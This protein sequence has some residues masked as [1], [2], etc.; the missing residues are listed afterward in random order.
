MMIVIDFSI[1]GIDRVWDNAE[2]AA[3][4]EC[5]ALD[6]FGNALPAYDGAAVVVECP[7]PG[8][9]SF[10]VGVLREETEAVVAASG[11]TR[12]TTEAGVDVCRNCGEPRAAHNRL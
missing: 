7:Q 1:G 10:Y 12:L 5:V 3:A 4:I 6:V 8:G 2:I 11:C 9:L